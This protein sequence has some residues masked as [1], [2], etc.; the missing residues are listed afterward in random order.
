VDGV[1][2]AVVLDPF[3]ASARSGRG[4]AFLVL[5]GFVLSF[6]FIRTSARM[7]RAQVSW[8]PGNVETSSGLHLHHLVWGISLMFVTGFL[9]FALDAG[10]PWYQMAAALFGVGAG[11]TADEFALWV[12]L[13]DV[14]WT[15]EG[16]VSLD[17]VIFV[18]AFMALVVIGTKPFGLD[19]P[20]S[21]VVTAYVVAQTIVLSGISFFKGRIALGLLAIFVWPCGLWAACRLAMPSSPWARRFYGDEKLARAR[22]RFPPDRRGVRL[23]D[24]FFDAI[25]GRVSEPATSPTTETPGASPR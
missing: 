5:L 10:A 15:S 25:G 14:Y 7:I 24:S 17:A 12:R 22:R 19:E 23:R 21:V 3:G 11:L 2:F 20:A 9:G 16:R 6:L 13:D 1:S 18:V 8:W 4:A